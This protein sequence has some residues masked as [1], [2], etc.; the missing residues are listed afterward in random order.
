MNPLTTK[1]DVETLL[2][3]V[4]LIRALSLAEKPLLTKNNNFFL[5][6][7]ETGMFLTDF[8]RYFASNY[9]LRTLHKYSKTN[10]ERNLSSHIL[11]KFNEISRNRHL[12]K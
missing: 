3:M 6:Q 12:S 1:S 4:T 7:M 2:L 10:S 5:S 9:N 8:L 11:H